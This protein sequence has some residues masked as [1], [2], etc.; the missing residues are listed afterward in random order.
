MS[1]CFVFAPLKG[2]S[3]FCF[4][5]KRVTIEQQLSIPATRVFVKSDYIVVQNRTYTR[6]NLERKMSIIY[7]TPSSDLS[8]S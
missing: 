8:N 6:N 3:P 7:S 1:G 4:G 5:E 2:A